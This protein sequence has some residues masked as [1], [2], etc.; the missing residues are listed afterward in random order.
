MLTYLYE[1]L[2]T[3]GFWHSEPTQP[4]SITKLKQLIVEE[5]KRYF[6]RASYETNILCGQDTKFLNVKAGGTTGLRKIKKSRSVCLVTCK[7]ILSFEVH[8]APTQPRNVF[9]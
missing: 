3:S 8:A 1:S 9:C 4:V 7:T 2:I 6:L 5:N